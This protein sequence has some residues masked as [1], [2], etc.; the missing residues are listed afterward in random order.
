MWFSTPYW[1]TKCEINDYNIHKIDKPI[2]FR[3]AKKEQYTSRREYYVFVNRN[4]FVLVVATVCFYVTTTHITHENMRQVLEM[5]SM[6]TCVRACTIEAIATVKT[7]VRTTSS[8]HMNFKW[9]KRT[10][11]SMCNARIQAHCASISTYTTLYFQRA[12]NLIHAH[13]T[14]AVILL[15]RIQRTNQRTWI[16]AFYSN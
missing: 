1:F 3:S 15:S 10:S 16:C 7:A 9:W 4:P 8:I 6:V 13:C 5:R 2:W 12:C 11:N 14:F